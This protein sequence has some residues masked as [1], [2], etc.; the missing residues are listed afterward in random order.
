MPVMS[1]WIQRHANHLH[2]GAEH[3]YAGSTASATITADQF[4]AVSGDG[5]LAPA[6]A[7]ATTVVGYALA[8]AASGAPVKALMFGP[9]VT[10]VVADANGVTAGEKLISAAAGTVQSIAAETNFSKVIGTA[11]TTAADTATVRLV[12]HS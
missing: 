11:L 4:L 9:V 3:I 2:E 12:M 5:T 8:G 10:A 6:G 7:S 1:A